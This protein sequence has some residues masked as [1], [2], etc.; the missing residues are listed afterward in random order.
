MESGFFTILLGWI[1]L[2]F[3][4][5]MR[6]AFSTCCAK[7]GVEEGLD[8]VVGTSYSPTTSPDQGR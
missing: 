2:I 7:Y 8:A 3:T 4:L 1:G 6:L 5:M